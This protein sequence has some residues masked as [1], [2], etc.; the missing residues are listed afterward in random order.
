MIPNN[1]QPERWPEWMDL[2]TLQGYAN[3]S[4][5]SIRDWIHLPLNPLPASQVAGGK[6]LVKRNTFDLW[7]EAHRFQSVTSIDVVGVANEIINE[8]R[9]AA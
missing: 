1:L 8:F 2:K 4:D 3:A 7:L 9:K 6:I 5:R